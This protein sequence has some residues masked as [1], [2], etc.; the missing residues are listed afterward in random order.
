MSAFS[1]C[2][3]FREICISFQNN[4]FH[5]PY[6]SRN[7]HFCIFHVLYFSR[8]MHFASKQLAPHAI[9]LEK[10]AFLH[11]PC[12]VI[13]EKY[14][15]WHEKCAPR[16]NFVPKKRFLFEFCDGNVSFIRGFFRKSEFRRGTAPKKSCPCS[17]CNP[18]WGARNSRNRLLYTHV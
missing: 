12:V 16:S 4:M 13:L 14:A 8:N 2:R 5:M 15:F 1:L 18:P 10:Y 9:F 3:I 6:F 17:P 7:T 11:F